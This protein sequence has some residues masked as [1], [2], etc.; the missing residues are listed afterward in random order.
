MK[1]VIPCY[2][3]LL[4]EKL[5][6]DGG[7]VW[8]NNLRMAFNKLGHDCEMVSL[9]WTGEADVMICQSEWSETTSYK[10]FKGKKI[11]LAGHFIDTVYPK[12]KEIKADLFLTT[13]KGEC[14]K[15]YNNAQFIPHAYNNLHPAKPRKE[16]NKVMWCGNKYALRDEGWLEGIG[17]E[18]VKTHPSELDSVYEGNVCANIH[19][20]CQLGIVTEDPSKILEEPGMMIN[21]R[22]WTVIGAGGILIQ[23]YHPQILDFFEEDE[24]IMCK[25]KEEFQEKCRYY[26][27]HRDEGVEFY[28]RART[29][30]LQDHLYIHRAKNIIYLLGNA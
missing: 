28:K 12:V 5:I 22:F 18:D 23:Q 16:N 15:R 25:T 26:L 6:I 19:A 4:D 9:E 17:V 20:D 7:S 10:A 1:I 27:E 2:N 13:W 8:L 24:I 29:K 14:T 30:V 21:E 11:I 3:Y